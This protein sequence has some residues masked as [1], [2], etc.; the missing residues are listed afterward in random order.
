MIIAL[1]NRSHPMDYFS[2]GPGR[3]ASSRK[4]SPPLLW[5]ACRELL[6]SSF[7]PDERTARRFWEFFTANIPNDNTRPSYVGA[8]GRVSA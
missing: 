1:I 7:C 8:A 6:R 3:E 4:F 2:P 5:A